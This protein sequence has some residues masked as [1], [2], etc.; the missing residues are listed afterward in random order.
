MTFDLKA[1][2]PIDSFVVEIVDIFSA[3]R[4]VIAKAEEKM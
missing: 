2:S 3:L 1:D 4:D